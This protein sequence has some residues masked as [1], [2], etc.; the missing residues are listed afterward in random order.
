MRGNFIEILQSSISSLFLDS[1]FDHFI[2]RSHEFSSSGPGHAKTCL[3][4]YAN[5]KGASA[6]SD[7]H[8]CCNL[9]R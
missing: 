8:F 7:Q 1:H 3:M 5:N 4:P 2:I 9:L 6:Q